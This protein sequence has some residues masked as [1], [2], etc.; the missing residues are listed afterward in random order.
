MM[1]FAVR[2]TAEHAK[3]GMLSSLTLDVEIL[4]EATLAAGQQPN[5]VPS[6]PPRPFPEFSDF[7]LGYHYKICFLGDMRSDRVVPIG[8][9]G[10]HRTGRHVGRAPHHVLHDGPFSA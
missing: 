10:T 8:P 3:T 6:A 4:V 7:D 1:D 9:H 5:F 2:L